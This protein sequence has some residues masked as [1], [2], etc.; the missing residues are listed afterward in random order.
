MGL[1]IPSRPFILLSML[2]GLSDDLAQRLVNRILGNKADNLI[3][4]FAAFED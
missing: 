2:L 3:G 4:Y 1:D